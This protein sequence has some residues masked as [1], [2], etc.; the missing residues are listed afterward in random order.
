M[1]EAFKLRAGLRADLLQVKLG[2]ALSYAASPAHARNMQAM[3]GGTGRPYTIEEIEVM[4]GSEA[5]G[6]Y[7][8]ILDATSKFRKAADETIER[9]RESEQE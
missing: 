2:V 4:Y 9:V 3:W 7:A 8:N 6:H 5:A 1:S